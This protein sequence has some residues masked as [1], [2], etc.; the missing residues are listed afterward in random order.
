MSSGAA[1]SLWAA[2]A[3]MRSRSPDA[4]SATAPA[5]IGPLRLPP[6]PAPNGVTA[7]SPW[8][9]CTSAMSAPRASA[10]SWTTVVSRLLP[11]DPPAT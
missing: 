8:T 10:T 2:M 4:V 11:H 9:V 1:S 3:T 6:V 5:S 7:V